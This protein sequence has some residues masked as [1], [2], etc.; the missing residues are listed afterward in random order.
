VSV[1]VLHPSWALAGAGFRRWS[2]YRQAAVA[3]VFVNTVFGVIK[4]SI[5]LGVADSAGGTVAGY[6]AESLSTY[7][8]MSQGMIAVVLIF[9]WTELADR[10]RTGDIAVDLARPVDL[11]LAWLA[12]DLG[13]AVWGLVSRAL[14]PIAFGAVFFGF[15]LPSNRWMLALL[16]VSLALAVV[17]SF[18]CRF[19]LNLVAFWIT[20]IRGLVVFYVLLSGMLG[21]HLIPVQLFP[22]W[23]RTVALATPFPAM[24]QWPINLVTGQT[25]GWAAVGLVVAQLGWAVVLLV[26]GRVVLA[27][28]TRKLVV[29]G[30]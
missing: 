28:A 14:V 29:Q 21:G 30:G 13:R 26:L 12:A 1:S 10:V 4:L 23:L 18:A 17:V 11:Q 9:G 15:A 24:I 25:E 16:P 22:D 19:M 5:L 27:R 7:T 20:E 2:T 8:W 3:G 6:D